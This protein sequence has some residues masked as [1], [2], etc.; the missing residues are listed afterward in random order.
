MP[1]YLS[2]FLAHFYSPCA[3]AYTF[4]TVFTVRLLSGRV[5]TSIPSPPSHQSPLIRMNVHTA[6]LGTVENRANVW[7]LLPLALKA[8]S[9]SQSSLAGVA[10]ELMK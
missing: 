2:T 8:A 3:A 4:L 10:A 9:V 6:L 7:V 1:T 5:S